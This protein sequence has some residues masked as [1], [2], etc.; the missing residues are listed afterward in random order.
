MILQTPTP[1]V[2]IHMTPTP[3]ADIHMTP[4]N[5]TLL[6]GIHMPQDLYTSVRH[7]APQIST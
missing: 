2:G 4:Q 5:P 6:A 7:M 1:L 3:L